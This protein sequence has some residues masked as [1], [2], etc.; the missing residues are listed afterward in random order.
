MDKKEKIM[1]KENPMGLVQAL[2]VLHEISDHAEL[3]GMRS[4]TE[5]FGT[6]FRWIDEMV[7]LLKKIGGGT[8][9]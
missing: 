6:V 4:Y 5:A 2:A 7:L 8:D 1:E 9:E 3:M